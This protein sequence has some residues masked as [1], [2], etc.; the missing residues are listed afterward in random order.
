MTTHLAPNIMIGYTI[1][2]CVILT[3]K[4]LREYIALNQRKEMKSLILFQSQVKY[5]EKV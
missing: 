4:I 2:S 5:S 3:P 1:S